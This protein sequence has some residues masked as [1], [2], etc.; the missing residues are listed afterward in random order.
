MPGVLK[1][2]YVV[3]V[4]APV[5]IRREGDHEEA[6][7]AG[8]FQLEVSMSR[9]PT[10]LRRVLFLNV[11][12]AAHACGSTDPANVEDL[13]S[14]VDVT[15]RIDTLIFLGET[16]QLDATAFGGSGRQI[17]GGNF[18]WTS[19]SPDVVSVS[20][21]GLVTAVADG[22]AA[23]FA[24]QEGVV[25]SASISVDRMRAIPHLISPAEGA[26]LDNGCSISSTDRR[27]W[28]FD[29]SDVPGADSYQ[30]IV[31]WP[32][33]IVPV[34]DTVSTE[35]AVHSESS[36]WIGPDTQ[37]GWT[38]RVRSQLGEL[39]GPWSEERTFDAEPVNTDCSGF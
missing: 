12:A 37:F 35:S 2:L 28:D 6:H 26:V 32:P 36:G 19:A 31:I 38:W 16:V 20:S 15:P 27:V 21:T 8:R 3:P 7:L 1:A 23:I 14:R 13:I 4:L 18:A 5:R 22:T 10:I 39:Q 24:S 9:F 11:L 29:W 17:S 34:L 33:Y 30:L 25:G